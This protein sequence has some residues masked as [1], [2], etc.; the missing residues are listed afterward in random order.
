MRRIINTASAAA[1]T[2]A[3]LVATAAS[4]SAEMILPW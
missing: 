2:A 4:A 1:I 3:V